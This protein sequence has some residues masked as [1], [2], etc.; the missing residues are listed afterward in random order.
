MD[1]PSF[2]NELQALRQEQVKKRRLMLIGAAVVLVLGGGGVAF[3]MTSMA[4]EKKARREGAWNQASTCVVGDPVTGPEAAATAFRNA[5]LSAM[6]VALDKRS[7][8]GQRAWPERCASPM[9]A[10]AEAFEDDGTAS[11]LVESSKSL[12]KAL[13][14]PDGYSRD[15][16]TLIAQV[17]EA[18]GALGL[19]AS[20]VNGPRPPG[21][22]NPLT[23]DSLPET[24]RFL[25]GMVP[26]Q[27]LKTEFTPSGRLVF[28]VD[29]KD[30]PNLPAL[31]TFQP[32][33][34]RIECQVLPQNLK[35]VCPGLGLFGTSEESVPPFVFA[36]DRGKA[37]IYRSTDGDQVAQGLT[38]GASALADGSLVRTVWNEEHKEVWYAIHPAAGKTKETKL[39]EYD[40]VGNPYYNSG[41]FWDWLVYKAWVGDSIKLL[42]RKVKPGGELEKVQQVGELGQ[43]SLVVPGETQPHITACRTK[44]AL[45]VR[46]K[47]SNE[48]YTAF[49]LGDG[50]KPPVASMGIYGDLTCSETEA[51]ITHL[52][53]QM[54]EPWVYQTRCTAAACQRSELSFKQMLRDVPDL[55]PQD[56]QHLTAAELNGKLLV[57]WGGGERGGLRMRLAPVD[58]I[59]KAKDNVVF[60]DLVQDGKQVGVSTLV[61]TRLLSGSK[62]A[63][64]FLSTV[65]GLYVLHVDSEGVLT[66]V[67]TAFK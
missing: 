59:L 30:Q 14:Q 19:Q 63:L 52:V 24:A 8:P 23:Q 40:E 31:C 7:E 27:A 33:K 61:A 18:A 34:K 55:K 47:G 5:Q 17:W 46:V 3:A 54:P 25:P 9:H 62:Y 32:D 57:L 42:A 44:E 65:K 37:G 58:Q 29:A 49:H 64:L 41:L 10:L 48:Q 53:P 6:G 35:R 36:G 39:L 67:T 11:A 51:V 4:A 28:L 22:T 56:K 13:E 50:W 15:A 43:R 26:L 21:T 2:D 38:Y 20:S 16:S 1:D 66:P 60:D 12:A 45:V